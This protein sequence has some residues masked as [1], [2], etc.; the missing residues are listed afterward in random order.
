M[1]LILLN[2]IH[3]ITP[4]IL[5]IVSFL[6]L[7][8]LPAAPERTERVVQALTQANQTSAII[9]LVRLLARQAVVEGLRAIPSQPFLNATEQ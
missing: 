6:S 2:R 8:S 4:A 7:R 3:F 1:V 9:T 5:S